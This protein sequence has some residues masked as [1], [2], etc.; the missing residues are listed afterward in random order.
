M[1]KSLSKIPNA[2]WACIREIYSGLG[3][4]TYLANQRIAGIEKDL[5][6]SHSPTSLLRAEQVGSVSCHVLSKYEG[7]IAFLGCLFQCLTTSI[8]KKKPK[9][10]LMFTWNSVNFNLCRVPLVL[11]LRKAWFCLFYCPLLI[12]VLKHTDHAFPGPSLLLAKQSQMP[13]PL[14]QKM[15]Q[16]LYHLHGLP[17]SLFQCVHV[18]LTWWSTDLDP[19]VQVCLTRAE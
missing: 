17:L 13:Q 10:F 9:L 1:V 11:S 18:S 19:A 8:V 6:R 15:L 4:G 2:S 16:S 3:W 14:K 12:R 7:S 5:W